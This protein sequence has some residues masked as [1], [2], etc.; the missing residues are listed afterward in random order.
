MDC[1]GRK[2]WTRASPP[3]PC[4][5]CS[6]RAVKIANPRLRANANHH[7]ICFWFVAHIVY[8]SALLDIIRKEITP[9]IRN[10]KVD[11]QY[12]IEQCPVFDAAFNETL[13][14]TTGANS[15][16]TVDAATNIGHQTLYPSAKLLIP[17]RQLHYDEEFFG[18]NVNTFNPL[19]FLDNKDLHKSPYFKPFGGGLTYCSGRFLA[20]REVMGLAAVI[21]TQYE[22]N[23]DNKEKGFPRLDLNKPNVG[24]M[25]SVGGDDVLLEIRPRV[26]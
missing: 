7:K 16:R 13:R 24:V 8:D 9:A 22:L 14:L 19:R 25:D 26:L 2:C 17:Y 10:G 4:T 21:L 12:L 11:I 23:I 1:S 18:P 5:L 15:A 6:C 20:R 3:A